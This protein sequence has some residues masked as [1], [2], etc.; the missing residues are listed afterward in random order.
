MVTSNIQVFSCMSIQREVEENLPVLNDKEG[1]LLFLRDVYS[2]QE[3]AL[4]FK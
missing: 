3:W 4:K 1:I 2:N